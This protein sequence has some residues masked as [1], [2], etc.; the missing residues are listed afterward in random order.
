M[1]NSHELHAFYM[2]LHVKSPS[3][4]YKDAINQYNIKRQT[5]I[6]TPLKRRTVEMDNFQDPQV[7]ILYN[8]VD[9]Y[10]DDYV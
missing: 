1:L 4:R 2:D 5:N 3:R 9:L 6:K 7:N 10:T 8:L